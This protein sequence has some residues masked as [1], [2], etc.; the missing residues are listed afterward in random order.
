[1]FTD[2]RQSVGKET[3]LTWTVEKQFIGSGSVFS[4]SERS[5]KERMIGVKRNVP[6][7]DDRIELHLFFLIGQ[8]MSREKQNSHFERFKMNTFLTF[9]AE[10]RQIG[11]WRRRR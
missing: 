7:A 8:R 5:Y 9:E 6:D 2:I 4:I 11:R 1:M 3:A 10:R